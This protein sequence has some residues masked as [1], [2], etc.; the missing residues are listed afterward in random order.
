MA[1]DQFG[2]SAGRVGNHWNAGGER[3]ENNPR[4]GIVRIRRDGE[5]I[6]VAEDGG[7]VALPVREVDGESDGR[8]PNIAGETRSR[9]RGRSADQEP[10]VIPPS[11]DDPGRAQQVQMAFLRRDPPDDSYAESAVSTLA[12]AGI[13]TGN[14]AVDHTQA[15]GRYVGRQ[16]AGGELRRCNDLRTDK[17]QTAS[18]ED[19]GIT[20]CDVAVGVKDQRAP[21]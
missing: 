16:S 12:A 2:Y 14:A 6:D 13:D 4:S 5:E 1:V 3:L 20:L 7:D 10:H 15:T 19:T 17:P 18:G 21:G 11:S 8:G 9:E